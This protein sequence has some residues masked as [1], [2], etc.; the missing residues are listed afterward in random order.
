M[1]EGLDNKVVGPVP[2]EQARDGALANLHSCMDC[3]FNS[4]GV[5]SR[6]GDACSRNH[7]CVSLDMTDAMAAAMLKQKRAAEA[8]EAQQREKLKAERGR[9]AQAKRKGF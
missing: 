6:Y 8:R 7:H 3:R 1:S 5:C 4:D 9:D 2:S